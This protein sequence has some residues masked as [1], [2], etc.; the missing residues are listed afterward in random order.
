MPGQTSERIE[1]GETVEQFMVRRRKEVSGAPLKAKAAHEAYG[2]ALRRPQPPTGQGLKT[3]PKAPPAAQGI[4]HPGLAESFIPFWGSGREAIAEWQD[5]HPIGAALNASLLVLDGTLVAGFA[6]K[7][8]AKGGMYALRGAIGR[9]A[10]EA[11]WRAVRKAMVGKGMLTKG[12]PGHHWLLP[13]RLK[14]VPDV[15]RN[16]PFNI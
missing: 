1:N 14:L 4:G 12:L 9:P 6:R 10:K 15:I 13:Q 3:K 2:K 8:L 5:G 11:G 16:H 7:V